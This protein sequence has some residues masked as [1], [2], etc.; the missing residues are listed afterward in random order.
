V[1]LKSYIVEQNVEILKQYQAILIYGENEGI[2]DDIKENI[3]IKNAKCE[4]ITLF[5]TD[6]LKNNLLQENIFNPSLFTEKKIIFIHEASDKIYNQVT[7]CLEKE[8]KDIEIYILAENLEKKSK[9]RN[10]FEKEKKLASFA[11]YEDNERTLINYVSGELQD[12]KGLTG[13]IN[14]L[15]IT[16]SGM[17]RKIIKNEIIKI[18]NFFLEKKINIDEIEEILNIKKD[19][20]FDE[21]RDKALVG[22][23]VKINKLLSETEI[24]KEEVFFYLN[25]INYR[26][27]KLYEILKLCDEDKKNYEQIISTMK[28]PIFWK[29]KPIILKQLTKWSLEKLEKI[30][31]KIGETEVLIKK[32]SHL[33]SDVVIKD[34]IIKLT[35]R[36]S[37][38]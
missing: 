17:N 11:C 30:L 20:G 2:K 1:I 23:K 22:E 36:A 24:L 32:N 28:P 10:L 31:I 35:K 26:V 15:I 25:S 27:M 8:N 3:K 33:R 14:N 37:I 18:K 34:L 9:L 6:I 38:S 16:N 13:E 4:I 5:E 21:I 19:N 12:F 7:E 29:D